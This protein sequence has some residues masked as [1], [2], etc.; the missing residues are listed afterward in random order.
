MGTL[1]KI[2]AQ[3]APKSFQ[4]EKRAVQP[5]A[6]VDTPITQAAWKGLQTGTLPIS[7]KA[8]DTFLTPR[9]T[10]SDTDEL[11]AETLHRNN[12]A[13]SLPT[14]AKSGGVLL[15]TG[16]E[17]VR[18]HA[19]GQIADRV[20]GELAALDRK[21]SAWDVAPYSEEE[22]KADQ[23]RREALEDQLYRAREGAY[24]EG[25]RSFGQRLNYGAASIA[26]TAGASLPVLADTTRQ[27][28]SNN[29]QQSS[30][31]RRAELA[32][33]IAE[34]GGRLDYLERYKY[35]TRYAAR[36]S[37]E[38]KELD[39][40]RARLREELAALDVN[41]PVSMDA[42]GM[43]M[44]TGAI[45]T[46][47]KALSG[48]EGVPRFLGGTALSI[49]QNLALMP[50]A[51]IS[52]AVPLAA[53]GAIAAADK[54]YEL[55]SRG[56][57]PGEALTRGLVSGGIEAA[58]EKIPLD[59]LLD[60]VKTGG[61]SA[62]RS[63]LRQM[64]TEAT[65]ES[66]SY[67]LNYIADKA[68]KD[69]E[70]RFSLQ[71]LA[72]SAAGG[73]LS[74][75]VL[76]GGALL[77]NKTMGAG[78]SGMQSAVEGLPDG[79]RGETSF[80][81]LPD[82]LR[83]DR[84]IEL[85]P[86]FKA[87]G[88]ANTQT[89]GSVQ[90]TQKTAS[91]G[92]TGQLLLP[93]RSEL[94]RERGY[95]MR[96]D[97]VVYKVVEIPQAKIDEIMA[98]IDTVDSASARKRY[99]RILKNLFSGQTF[100]NVNTVANEIA[101]EVG[102]SSKG[103][104]EIIARQP[105]NAETLAML[106]QLNEIVENA[107]YVASEPTSHQERR[108]VERTDL[109]ETNTIIG[110]QPGV[111]KMRVNVTKDG[112]KLYFATNEKTEGITPQ[113]RADQS[114]LR[115]I[116][117][118]PSATD[119]S[120]PQGDVGVKGQ[121]A[122]AGPETSVGAAQAGF[123][124][125]TERGYSKNLATDQN[126]RED[127][128]EDFRLDPEM[129]HRLGNK[130]TLAKAQ[131]IFDEGLGS[132]RS[133]LEQAIGAAQ[134]GAK[135]A[136]EM[137]PLSRLVANE[138]ARGG[139]LTAARN[140][141]SD[142]AVE[143]TQ[144]GQL[145]QAAN[146][147][148]SADPV[149]VENTIQ[150][151]LDRVNEAG[152]KRYGEKWS[153]FALTDEERQEIA[154]IDLGDEDAFSAMYEK[155][156]H[157]VGAEMPSTWWEKLT[158]IRRVSMLLNPKTQV[159][160][161]VAN[162]PLAVERK[163]AERLSGAIQDMLVKWGALD[164]QDQTRTLRVSRG[165][166]ALAESLY[167][168]NREM[169]AGSADKWDMN[170]LLRQY[171][172]YFGESKPGQAMDAVR[173]FTYD[174]LEKGDTPFVRS[175]FL[176]NAAQYIE[177]QGYTSLDQVPQKVVDHAAQQAMEATF[178]DACAL[179]SWLNGVKRRGG[180][181]GGAADIILPFTT[182]PVNILRRTV[183]YSPAGA[184]QALLD[185]RAGRR[186]DA[187]DDIARALTGTGA[188][189]IGMLLAKYGLATGAADDDKD[190]AALDRATGESPY[191]LGG[192][193]AYEWAQPVG[194]QLAMGAR[195]W[196][197]VKDQ[198]KVSDALLNVLY[199]GG[200]T[201]MDMTILSNLQDLLKGYGSPTETVGE[202]LIQGFAGQM[203]PSLFGA[204]A[205]TL[206]GTVRTSY[207]GGGAWDNAQAGI[208]A[209]L[210]GLS[211]TLPASVNVKGEENRRVEP[212]P[213]RALQEMVNPSSVNTGT[214]NEVDDEVYR[215]YETTGGKTMFPQVSPYK[216]EREGVDVPLT[217]AERARF[218]TTQGHTY[219]SIIGEMLDSE[220]YRGMEPEQQV[221]YFEL[222]NQYAKAVAMEEAT[223]GAYESDRYVELA[224]TAKKE[225]GLSEAEYLLLYAQ[226]GGATM[227]GDGIRT[228][229]QEGVDP[230]AYL[231]YVGELKAVKG[232]KKS[233]GQVDAA[234]A[235]LQTEGLTDREREALWGLQGESWK[236]ESNPFGDRCTA[237]RERFG[238]DMDIFLDALEIYRGEGKAAEKKAALRALIGP[239]GNA[240]Y[241]QLGK[242]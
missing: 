64:G 161:V 226:Y 234:R 68:A 66:V 223:D 88:T 110:D 10:L 45:E 102:I 140:L 49:G 207:T 117:G 144:A 101:Y 92:E 16:A 136:P 98:Y 168:E 63:L 159:R 138:L 11:R 100:Q 155:V 111:A 94:A 158:E 32:G 221:K 204:V 173:Q 55:N 15:P 184:V 14:Q 109:F 99:K 26:Q 70:A 216:I 179:A 25:E 135:L 152:R 28:I 130:E 85:L 203:T 143:L 205:R 200:D 165:S 90:Q 53:M 127:I 71:E 169:L 233:T 229:Y 33:Q 156:A 147:L 42:P 48:T 146:I 2:G 232:D 58:T 154:G 202:T 240:L 4:T 194:T 37:E 69:P 191:S 190:K 231:R 170:G 123:T 72:A 137:V 222:V 209:K 206:D 153:D 125:D 129:Y 108:G 73:A 50:T 89:M 241:D 52:P 20:Q 163:A 79:L 124:G 219:Y 187:A 227:N 86:D 51:A 149:T 139:D 150:G 213:L 84:A 178:K 23:D 145:G 217:G 27:Y 75:G 212:L 107:K 214:R 119:T 185:F 242:R 230:E 193:V 3:T 35:P 151:A 18:E 77:V 160:N 120:L 224:Q 180:A 183:D 112:N 122:Q 74:G 78:N 7:G 228:A 13:V 201:L 225:L 208:K 24:E 105:V 34:L 236:E 76:G 83:Q 188:I 61:R 87:A 195:I 44:M 116:E 167:A 43:Q 57:A 131:A 47:E 210:P 29:E 40:E 238:L 142:V 56:V 171:R 134:A 218:Q 30:D 82:G 46:R 196:D 166:R 19:A 199:A 54:T 114:R 65:E 235:L 104:G 17:H 113:P 22:R 126:M 1:R 118:D 103:I 39:A 133:K 186:T 164:K 239:Q 192:R 31:P 9:S 38:W 157:R 67:V 80:V 91:T 177:A 121:S 106:E 8:A 60:L 181:A 21:Y 198:E 62:V 176:D 215:L 96:R 115:G 162:V 81:S 5:A 174:L 12:P 211:A 197:A 93:E 6:R 189:L 36:Q 41:T 172:R 97:G 141:L 175:A 182:T 132:A 95:P 148:R 128:R 220:D 237:I 59:N